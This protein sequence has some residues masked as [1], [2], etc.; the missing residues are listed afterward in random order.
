MSKRLPQVTNA[1][2]LRCM[3]QHMPPDTATI[4]CTFPG[5]PNDESGER[6]WK[7][8]G[9]SWRLGQGTWHLSAAGNNYLTISAFVID[10]QERRYRRTKQNFAQLCTVMVDDVGTKVP[11][12]KIKLPL[13]ATIETSP[14]NF[15]GYYRIEP[16]PAARDLET[17]LRLLD[18]MVRSGLTADGSDPGMKGV[19]RY[20][21]LP[22]GANGKGKYVEALGHPFAVRIT[23]W[24]PER[25][26]TVEAI[27]K[28]Y[29]LDISA[30]PKREPLPIA[31]GA[32]QERIDGFSGLLQALSDAGL[33]LGKR[34]EWHSIECPWA[35]EHS[36][37]A[38]S[39]TALVEPAE[40]NRWAGGFR[41]HHGHCQGRTIRDLYAWRDAFEALCDQEEA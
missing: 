31:A 2:F 21:R 18:Q 28:A 22:V 24:S 40:A 30:P 17:S 1:Q 23:Q 11:K 6:R 34:R 38:T 13:T 4:V 36:D 9:T 20:G 26:Y 10:P 12:S 3:F 35:D 14:R 8:R 7:W 19:T 25:A 39:G 16:S 41:C 27:A 15:Q 32:V 33:Y 29:G 5:D 37:R